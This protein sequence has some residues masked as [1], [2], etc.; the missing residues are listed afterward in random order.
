MYYNTIIAWAVYYLQVGN[1]RRLINVSRRLE[2]SQTGQYFFSSLQAS[3]TSV[4]PWTS[5]NNPW[6]T[7]EC[8]EIGVG[9]PEEIAFDQNITALAHQSRRVSP[10]QEYFE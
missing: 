10:A 4:L 1:R 5:C 9:A 6:N 3:F 8:S 7:P 2:P